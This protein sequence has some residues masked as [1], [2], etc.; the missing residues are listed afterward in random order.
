MIDDDG[1]DRLLALLQLQSELQLDCG[2]QVGAVA[3][4]LPVRPRR[5]KIQGELVESFEP[6]SIDHRRGIQKPDQKV[7][8]FLH[9]PPFGRAESFR[10]VDVHAV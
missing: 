9:R 10:P 1:L 6:G 5:R 4:Q 2:E 3:D 8:Q 7:G